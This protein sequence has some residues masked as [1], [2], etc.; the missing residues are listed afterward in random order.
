MPFYVRVGGA[1]KAAT[2]LFVR[3]GGA[4]KQVV[5]AWVRVGGATKNCFD[6]FSAYADPNPAYNFQ[7]SAGSPPYTNGI[8]VTMVIENAIGATSI[9]SVTRQSGNSQQISH[10]VSSLV[11][12]FSSGTSSAAYWFTDIFDVVVQ[13]SGGNSASVEVTVILEGEP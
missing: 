13:D 2:A 1:S 3:V 12:T 11:I 8:N 7:A 10:S 5:N 4:T 6:T 9:A